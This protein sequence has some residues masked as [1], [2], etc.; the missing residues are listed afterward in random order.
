MNPIDPTPCPTPR[1]DAFGSRPL[2]TGREGHIPA[3]AL[4]EWSDFS[5]Q[6]ETELAQ[7]QAEALAMRA[8]R[9]ELAARHAEVKRQRDR[10]MVSRDKA[11][12]M[13]GFVDRKLRERT[14]E[15][16]AANAL[17]KRLR[18]ELEAMKSDRDA[19]HELVRGGC[20]EVCSTLRAELATERGR[21]EAFNRL[22]LYTEDA[23][24]E[25]R[26][27]NPN[28]HGSYIEIKVR[29]PS[30][31]LAQAQAELEKLRN[32]FSPQPPKTQNHSK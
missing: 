18:V 24:V 16:D 9:D 1:T 7:A 5:R 12:D 4:H 22:L 2:D 26:Y 31:E 21:L 15:R 8:E 17:V 32:T 30:A 3:L 28:D 23:E 14:S 20:C 11:R 27:L 29:A 25:F 19:L 13:Y 6:L 10:L